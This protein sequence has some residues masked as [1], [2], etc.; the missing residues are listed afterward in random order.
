MDLLCCTHLNN[1][2]MMIT[3]LCCSSSTG[4]QKR[5]CK[6]V[7][8]NV[9]KFSNCQILLHILTRQQNNLHFLCVWERERQ[10]GLPII[11]T[12]IRQKANCQ[13]GFGYMLAGNTERASYIDIYF[14]L[15]IFTFK[16]EHYFLYSSHVNAKCFN[17]IFYLSVLMEYFTL[18]ISV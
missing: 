15:I 9:I 18:L 7:S 2:K 1:R 12:L 14:I 8:D 17:V 5:T 6:N 11:I 13:S 10:S 4:I 3:K 16:F